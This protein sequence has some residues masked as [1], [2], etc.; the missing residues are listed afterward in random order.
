METK[1]EDSVVCVCVCGVGGPL[2]SGSSS[3]LL[4]RGLHS[5]HR[6]KVS[7]ALGMSSASLHF[8]WQVSLLWSP[9]SEEVI[10]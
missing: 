1:R 5:S 8:M 2:E 6:V 10:G 4:Q 9:S 7:G 3:F